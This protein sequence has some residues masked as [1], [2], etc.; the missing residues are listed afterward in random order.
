MD[1]TE[2]AE[3]EPTPVPVPP[4]EDAPSSTGVVVGEPGDDDGPAPAASGEPA[5]E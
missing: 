4:I 3:P 1:D 5:G 2:Q